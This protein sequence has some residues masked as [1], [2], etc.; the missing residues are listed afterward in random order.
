MLEPLD[1][2][3]YEF[4]VTD[5]AVRALTNR[6]GP[7]SSPAVSP[8]G[9]LIAAFYLDEKPNSPFRIM[10]IPFEGGAALKTFDLPPTVDIRG[11]VRWTPDGRAITYI[12]TRGTP[13]LWSQPLDGGPPKQLTNWKADPIPAFDWSRD[14]KWLAYAVGSMTS[15]VVLINDARR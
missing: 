1:S 15:D 14:G 4:S 6:K 5:G 9:K 10:V 12:D 11:S 7:D 2:E 13:N 3:I 8:D